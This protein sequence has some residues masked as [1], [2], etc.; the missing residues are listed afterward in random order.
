MNAPSHAWF[1]GYAPYRA[2]GKR[3]A[4]AVLVEHGQYGG[5]AA[6]PAAADLVSA[7]AKLGI[8]GTQAP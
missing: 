5:T 1:A 3:I 8:I 6:A 4:F 2:A 7:A